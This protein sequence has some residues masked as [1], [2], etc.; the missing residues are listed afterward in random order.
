M[1]PFCF[2]SWKFNPAQLRY[3]TLQKELLAI[4]NGLYF[5]EAQ[6]RAYK[7][8][9]MT[10]HKPLLTFIERTTDSRKVRRQQV[11]RITFESTMEHTARKDNHIKTLS[12]EY[13]TTQAY[14][15]LKMTLFLTAL[16]LQVS[17]LYKK[18]QPT[19]STFQINLLYLVPSQTTYTTTYYPAE[20]SISRMSTVILASAEA[21]SKPPDITTIAQILMK[22]IQNLLAKIT[23][24]SCRQRIKMCLQIKN[25]CLQYYG[26]FS[27][28]TKYP[29][30]ISISQMESATCRQYDLR[31]HCRSILLQVGLLLKEMH[32][33][34]IL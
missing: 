9:I 21:E 4:I 31:L 29:L 20:P 12:P 2:Y 3:S 25:L 17:D 8:M 19:T 23:T 16:T 7:F 1:R 28:S 13:I 27:G 26:S 15:S 30:P 11:V 6:L 14:P 34:I 33:Q 5:F 18:S 32:H 22:R 10:D 24:R